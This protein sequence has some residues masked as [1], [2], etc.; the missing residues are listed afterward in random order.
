AAFEPRSVFVVYSSSSSNCRS[1]LS[2]SCS[3]APAGAEGHQIINTG[4]EALRC[5]AVSN[6]A[7]ADV[8]EFL[9]SG[10][11]RV[12][13]GAT[14]HH[15][16]NAT[17]AAGGRLVPMGYWDGEKIDDEA[18]LFGQGRRVRFSSRLCEKMGFSDADPWP[19]AAA[20]TIRACVAPRGVL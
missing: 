19:A 10:R 8:I 13:I 6:N 7:N 3:A 5:L 11:I 9:D 14:G 18:R 20:A 2:P 4:T 16:E 1:R 17:F 15:R 12:H